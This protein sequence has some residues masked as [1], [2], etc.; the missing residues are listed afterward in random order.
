MEQYFFDDTQVTD[1][2]QLMTNIFIV[3]DGELL[4]C[5]FTLVCAIANVTKC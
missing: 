4:S 3:R 5:P 2:C 1:I